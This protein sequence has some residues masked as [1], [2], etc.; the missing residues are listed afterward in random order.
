[1]FSTRNY[2]IVV[3]F[4]RDMFSARPQTKDEGENS[5]AVNF[6]REDNSM[7]NDNTHLLTL[8]P[9]EKSSVES[10]GLCLSLCL[11][12]DQYLT[13]L[14]CLDIQCFWLNLPCLGKITMHP[15]LFLFFLIVDCS[16]HPSLSLSL[17]DLHCRQLEA[18]EK[19]WLLM[20]VQ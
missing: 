5:L 19:I 15:V 6:S 14:A 13:C 1:M 20:T 17:V 10:S 4:A 3:A 18:M 7:R 2:L 9:T 12:L 11:S 16:P 8:L